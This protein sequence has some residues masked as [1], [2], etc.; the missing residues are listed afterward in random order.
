MLP[1]Y[2][3]RRRLPQRRPGEDPAGRDSHGTGDSRQT[4]LRLLDGRDPL[5]HL[6]QH[7]PLR[8][9]GDPP[10]RLPAGGGRAA[11]HG[12]RHLRARLPGRRRPGAAGDQH[13]AGACARLRP[14]PSPLRP[15]IRDEDD[16]PSPGGSCRRFR[17]AAGDPPAGFPPA[18]DLSA[19][20][21]SIAEYRRLVDR[22]PPGG[23]GKH[24]G[25][26]SS[27]CPAGRR[28]AD[29]GRG[30]A[31]A[32]P[33]LLQLALS[34]SALHRSRQASDGALEARGGAAGTVAAAAPDP[35]VRAGRRSDPRPGTRQPPVRLPLPAGTGRARTDD[36]RLLRYFGAGRGACPGRGDSQS[37]FAPLLLPLSLPSGGAACPARRP[38]FP[39]GRAGS[40]HLLRLRSLRQGLPP[41]PDRQRG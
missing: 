31:A 18:D 32:G 40:G 15:V 13:R 8:R 26:P 14:P 35:V 16:P 37:L 39:A 9:P 11:L 5:P 10:G 36:G 1:V 2:E 22:L 21:V 3:V 29:A 28:H 17:A 30:G 33:G 7:L 19:R 25:I 27:P 38:A 20:L 4:R 24:P 6:L 12:L 23:A 34:H 41:R